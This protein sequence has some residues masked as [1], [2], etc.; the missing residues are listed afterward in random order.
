MSKPSNFN[1]IFL[2][3]II[4]FN[5]LIDNLQKSVC[6]ADKYKEALKT[7]QIFQLKETD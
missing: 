1:K 7:L 3:Y 2:K 4:Q 5:G 6:K